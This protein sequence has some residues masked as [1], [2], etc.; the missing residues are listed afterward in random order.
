[1]GYDG[2][3]TRAIAEAASV[4]EVTLF[5]HFGNKKNIF[6]AVIEQFSA[7]PGLRA[8][9]AEQL[10]GN[11]YED[12]VT[13]GN[14]FL[15]RM[16]KRRKAILMSLCAAERLPEIRDIVA[17]PPAQQQQM[18]SG[19]LR[20]Q[21][22]RGAVRDLPSPELAAKMFFGMLFEFA[23]SQPLLAGTPLEHMPPEEVVAQVVDVFV[24]GTMKSQEE[25][26]AG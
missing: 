19:Y 15:A 3:T 4:N 13:L 17:Q 9:L 10:T 26:D 23:I 16:L 22:E 11:Y 20:Q 1:M 7:L 25:S 8:A 12:L 14:H 24:R 21:I 6:M 18:L 2:A 5:R